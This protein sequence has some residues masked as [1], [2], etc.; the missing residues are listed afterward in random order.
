MKNFLIIFLLSAS[1]DLI[2]QSVFYVSP[3]GADS[4]P[5]TIVKPFATINAAL[6]NVADAKEKKV[7]IY[8]REGVYRPSETIVITTSLLANHELE[9]SAYK[10]EKVV[11]IGAAAIHPTWVVWK[12]TIM[13]AD[14]GSGLSFDRLLCNGKSL[15]MAR[16]PNFDSGKNIYFGTAPDAV[17]PERVKTWKN[18][19]GGYIHVLHEG[20]WGGFDYRIVGK[21]SDDSLKLEGGWQ[22]N[23]P[24]PW[25]KLYRFVENI[26]EEL[27]APGEWFYDGNSGILYLYPPKNVNIKT[28][29]LERSDLNEIIAIKGT[30]TLPVKNVTITGIYFTGTNRTF[31]LTKEPLLRSDWTIYRGGAILIEGTKNIQINN[32]IFNELGGNAIFVSNYNSDASIAHNHIYNVG[33]NA[34]AFAGSP[35]AVR[36]PSFQYNESVPIAQMDTLPGP[37]NNNYPQNC[38]V[39]D[40]LIHNIGTIEKQVTGVEISMSMNIQVS[41]NTIYNVPRAG[42]NIGDGCWGGNVIEFNDV[43]NTVLETG[44]HGA[45]NSWGRDRFWLPDIKKVDSIVAIY[46]TLPFLDIVKPNILRNNRFYCAHG[47]DIDLDDG[48][49]NYRIYNN[50]CLNGGLKLREGYNRVVENNVI[51]NNTFHPHVW[52]KNSMDVFKHNIVM[53]DYAPIMVDYW[54]KEIDS[55]FFLQKSSLAAAQQNGTDQHSITGNPDFIDAR[56][57]NYNVKPRSQALTIGFKNF[58]VNDF[59]VVSPELK[60]Q[61]EAPV[62]ADI[63]IISNNKQGAKTDWLGATIKNIETLGEQSAAGIPDKAGV[64]VLKVTTGSLAE[65]SGLKQGDVIRKI[66]TKTISNVGEMLTSLQVTFWASQVPATIIHNQKEEQIVLYLK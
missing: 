20:M 2:A 30:E 65:K 57:G 28:A 53:S 59:G 9:I 27:D 7:L 36:S 37:K 10:N 49:S 35:D 56:L 24:A 11:I 8:L 29:S 47:W 19:A 46:P 14:V 60:K 6:K 58:T 5:G 31:M 43:F 17:S 25:H 32:C 12:G 54:G 45:F 21:Y 1:H 52:Y 40:N 4:N 61:A 26:F 51:V 42:I 48:S 55:N 66:D 33:A 18:P 38:K 63:K 3:K 50:V 13:R 34:I 15:P 23:R 64:L 62:V 44:D 39:Y 22:N 41:H 16:Y